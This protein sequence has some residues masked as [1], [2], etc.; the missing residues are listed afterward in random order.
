M[1]NDLKNPTQVDHKII[2]SLNEGGTLTELRPA[3]LAVY[4]RDVYLIS[5]FEER[6]QKP[7]TITHWLYGGTLHVTTCQYSGHL[8][9]HGIDH[10]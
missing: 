1:Q 9:G 6:R 2:E 7:S 4:R 8:S 3:K 10:G 5:L